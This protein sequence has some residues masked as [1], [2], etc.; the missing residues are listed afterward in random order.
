MV[1]VA[2]DS[3]AFEHSPGRN[4]HVARSYQVRSPL[5]APQAA[6]PS[7]AASPPP[8]RAFGPIGAPPLPPSQLTPVDHLIYVAN[9]LS[10]T[11]DNIWNGTKDSHGAHTT[12]IQATLGGLIGMWYSIVD[13]LADRASATQIIIPELIAQIELE[14]QGQDE[15]GNEPDPNGQDEGGNPPP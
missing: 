11:I 7:R 6:H 10:R 9:E 3:M 14:G 2:L 1:L 5:L 13:D 4:P 15:E 12:P 8:T